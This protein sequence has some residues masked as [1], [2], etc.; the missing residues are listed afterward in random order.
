M[1]SADQVGKA[2]FRAETPKFRPPAASTRPSVG[3]AGPLA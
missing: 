3:S 1:L 2:A